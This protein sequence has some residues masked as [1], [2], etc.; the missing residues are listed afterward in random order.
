[1]E[2]IEPLFVGDKLRGGW[3]CRKPNFDLQKLRSQLT[4]CLVIS[5]FQTL[6]RRKYVDM[7]TAYTLISSTHRPI[8]LYETV[9]SRF[10]L[11]RLT[12]SIGESVQVFRLRLWHDKTFTAVTSK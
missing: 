2:F 6:C 5:I 4:A 9:T 3:N 12:I 10:F 11:A 8:E 7:S 1:M